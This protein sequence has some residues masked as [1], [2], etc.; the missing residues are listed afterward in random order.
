MVD[1]PPLSFDPIARAGELWERHVGDA[2]AMR[3]ATS[4]MRVQQLVIGE[5]DRALKPLGIT[6][7]R[8][9]VLRLLSFSRE[10]RLALSVIGERLMVHPTSVT[11]AI[12]RLVV[13]G[14]VKRTPDAEDRR[15][16][17]AELT[18][19]GTSVLKRGTQALMDAEFGVGVLSASERDRLYDVLRV[20]REPDFEQSS[21]ALG[22]KP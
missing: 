15:R 3:V 16:V 10:G 22:A 13:S 5:C 18:A 8:Y 4:I 12:D 11:N 19:E 6:F 9:E 1:K 20:I 2:S 14:L 17:F 7:A 21:D